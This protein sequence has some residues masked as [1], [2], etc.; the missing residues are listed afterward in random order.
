[1]VIR[2]SYFDLFLDLPSLISC[3][4]EVFGCSISGF[5]CSSLGLQIHLRNSDLQIVCIELRQD[6]RLRSDFHW[7]KITR[8]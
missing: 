3:S 4:R 5:V 2:L 1:M 7:Q 6:A 8:I